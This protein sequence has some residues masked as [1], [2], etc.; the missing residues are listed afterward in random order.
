MRVIDTRIRGIAESLTVVGT[1]HRGLPVVTIGVV[2]LE[3]YITGNL[4][5]QSKTCVVALAV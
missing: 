5:E 1:G 4:G 3:S 2:G